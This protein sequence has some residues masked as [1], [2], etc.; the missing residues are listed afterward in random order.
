MNIE[1]VTSFPT[2]VFNNWLT[3][4]NL[5]IIPSFV[6][7]AEQIEFYSTV[8]SIVNKTPKDNF[9]WWTCKAMM[10][11]LAEERLN[12]LFVSSEKVIKACDKALEIM[13]SEFSSSG[14]L[15]D[16]EILYE[17]FRNRYKTK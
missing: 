13:R 12:K 11:V 1:I 2:P 6:P 16:F 9:N 14:M 4:N 3:H 15:T 8:E 17:N 10:S 7:F 5:K